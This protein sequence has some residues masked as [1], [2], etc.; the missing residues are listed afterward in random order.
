MSGEV[1]LNVY[2]CEPLL[3]IFTTKKQKNMVLPELT[4]GEHCEYF[5]L[6]Q[7]SH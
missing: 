2:G 4:S 7:V 3:A 6:P 5:Q 1:R